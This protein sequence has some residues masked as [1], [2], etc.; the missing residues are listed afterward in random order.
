MHNA[1]AFVV[2]YD[3]HEQEPERGGRH[4]EKIDGRQ[5]AHMV[6]KECPPALRWRLRVPD[7]VF[8]NSGLTDLDPKLEK[9]A[10]DA[11]RAP[12]RILPRHAPDQCSDLGTDWRAASSPWT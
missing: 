11:W 12:R 5:T 1:T 2:P 3:E 4:D 9:F 6:P 7:H 8:G 10:M